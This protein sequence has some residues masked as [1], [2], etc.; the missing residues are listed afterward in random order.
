M[1]NVCVRKTT[2]DHL[3]YWLFPTWRVK[4]LL[5]IYLGPWTNSH[6][7][8]PPLS[9]NIIDRRS[10]SCVK[11]VLSWIKP[12]VLPNQTEL[13]GNCWGTRQNTVNSVLPKCSK[14]ATNIISLSHLTKS[15]VSCLSNWWLFSPKLIMQ[16]FQWL[17]TL[18]ASVLRP[19]CLP[20]CHDISS[21]RIT[22]RTTC[23]TS[24]LLFK[25]FQGLCTIWKKKKGKITRSRW[26]IIHSFIHHNFFK[27]KVEPR[28]SEIPGKLT[29][30]NSTVRLIKNMWFPK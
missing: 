24:R 14:C 3:R 20:G 26:F 8:H 16:W 17:V 30:C 29:F 23:D 28:L 10:F 2:I 7:L 25:V 4:L 22:F 18:H 5:C 1:H 19:V 12:A 13:L 6:P 9:H 21:P 11:G 15:P 27:T